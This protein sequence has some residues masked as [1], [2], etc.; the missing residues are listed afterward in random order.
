MGLIEA[1]RFCCFLIE[2]IM[3]HCNNVSWVFPIHS[4]HVRGVIHDWHL[5]PVHDWLVCSLLAW[6]FACSFGG[7]PFCFIFAS[8]LM[9][10]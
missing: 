4:M 5:I 7:A 3:L 1:A 10:V 8:V 2:F 9:E 6:F